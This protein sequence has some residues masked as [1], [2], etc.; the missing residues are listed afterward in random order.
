MI[1]TPVLAYNSPNL[2]FWT[3]NLVILSIV[4]FTPHVPVFF[5]A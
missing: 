2:K 1:D 5:L 3:L 4:V